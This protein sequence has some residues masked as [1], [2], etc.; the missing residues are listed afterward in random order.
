MC[1]AI[2]WGLG[3]DFAK[4]INSIRYEESKGHFEI[5]GVTDSYYCCDEWDGLKYVDSKLITPQ[6]CEYVIVTPETP[7]LEIKKELLTR[8]FVDENIILARS[9]LY[10]GF[11]FNKYTTIKKSKV[12][13]ISPNCFAGLAYHALGMEFYSP[14]INMHFGGETKNYLEFLKGFPDNID[15]E[16]KYYGT[17]YDSVLKRNYPVGKL[18][19]VYLYFNHYTDFDEAVDFWNR[20]KGKINYNNML[21]ILTTNTYEYL[22]EFEQIPLKRKICFSFMDTNSDITININSSEYETLWKCINDIPKGNPKT[23]VNLLDLLLGE[24]SMR[25]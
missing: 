18:N 23:S 8:G 11:D 20:R 22:R 13:I 2:I 16:V 10:P 14:T 15:G 7:F 3:L 1:K 24:S 6:M 5:L 21:F 12:S 17:E 9:F 19:N 4:S 25:S